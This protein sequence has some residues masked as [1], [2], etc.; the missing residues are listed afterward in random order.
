MKK[1]IEKKWTKQKDERKMF[2]T[3]NYASIQILP[4]HNQELCV[5]PN[6]TH[7]QPRIMC[8]SKFYPFTTKRY[9][10]IETPFVHFQEICVNWNIAFSSPRGMCQ[11]KHHLFISK[12]YVPIRN[13]NNMKLHI[14]YTISTYFFVWIQSFKPLMSR[15]ILATWGIKLHSFPLSIQT[16]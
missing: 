8:Q 7:S 15:V 14:L 16:T 5:N 11:L 1:M 3:K 13:W 6:S 10:F 9:V 4:I 12:R 2:T